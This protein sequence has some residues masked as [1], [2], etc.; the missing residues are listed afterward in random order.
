MT[1]STGNNYTTGGTHSK[2]C[3]DDTVFAFSASDDMLE[4]LSGM[5][6]RLL[7]PN[8]ALYTQRNEDQEDQRDEELD[9]EDY[10][11]FVACPR[12]LVT[13]SDRYRHS[14]QTMEDTRTEDLEGEGST[15]DVF[16]VP[17]VNFITGETPSSTSSRVTQRTFTR[18]TSDSLDM[19]E[20]NYGAEQGYSPGEF[21]VYDNNGSN[22]AVELSRPARSKSFTATF[23]VDQNEFSYKSY[24]NIIDS[25]AN[26]AQQNYKLWLNRV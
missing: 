10:L 8:S 7:R 25:F 20:Q 18:D 6:P 24:E 13:D 9:N 5:A 17:R 15:E 11:S 21:G 26:V 23:G 1:F 2:G 22:N 4:E 3:E 19:N 16:F 14:L 12:L